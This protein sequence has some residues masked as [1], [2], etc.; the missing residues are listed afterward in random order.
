[1][2][3]TGTVASKQTIF[4]SIYHKKEMDPMPSDGQSSL[5]FWSGELK[6]Y[7]RTYFE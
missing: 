5:G 4:E 7:N 6:T 1:M 3:K 2:I